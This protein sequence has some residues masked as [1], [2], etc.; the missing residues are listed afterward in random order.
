M[1]KQ[2]MRDLDTKRVPIER[3][4]ALLQTFTLKHSA[5]ELADILERSESNQ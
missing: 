1:N 2:V 5:R 3:L 4:S